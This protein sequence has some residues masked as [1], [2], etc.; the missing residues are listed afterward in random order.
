MMKKSI[1]VGKFSGDYNKTFFK[2][3]SNNLKQF[4]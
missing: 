1:L 2:K 3:I 4:T